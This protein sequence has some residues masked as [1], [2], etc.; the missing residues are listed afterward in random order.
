MSKNLALAQSLGADFKVKGDVISA[1]LSNT[2]DAN[3]WSSVADGQLL[4]KKDP[5]TYNGHL[6]NGFNSNSVTYGPGSGHEFEIDF[7]T[8]SANPWLAQINMD[9]TNYP[10]FHAQYGVEGGILS[11]IQMSGGN[12]TLGSGMPYSNDMRLSINDPSSLQSGQTGAGTGNNQYEGGW[13]IG[14][15]TSLLPEDYGMITLTEWPTDAYLLKVTNTSATGNPTQQWQKLYIERIQGPTDNLSATEVYLYIFQV[16]E[17]SAPV[18]GWE[19][20]TAN[21]DMSS[22]AD[23]TYLDTAINNLKGSAP[24]SLDTLKELSDAVIA[25][26]I[27][28]WNVY[29]AWNA[30]NS[31]ANSFHVGDGATTTFSFSHRPGMID[32]WVNGI[33]QTPMISSVDN[34]S[35]TPLEVLGSGYDYSSQSSSTT[36]EALTYANR[37]WQ[38]Y[39]SGGVLVYYRWYGDSTN[40]LDVTT[41]MNSF[42]ALGWNGQDA[43]PSFGV[44]WEYPFPASEDSKIT[45]VEQYTNDVF[46]GHLRGVR[47]LVPGAGQYGTIYL[48]PGN[49][50]T[51]SD[52]DT[53]LYGASFY[54]P[55]GPNVMNYD[56]YPGWTTGGT[57]TTDIS[58][59]Q[60]NP[61]AN[62][63]T[64][65]NPPENGASIEIRFW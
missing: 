42:S 7:T 3:L 18:P 12:P 60:A 30:E 10:V 8:D 16:M 43:I 38:A 40:H 65:A 6:I 27:S 33:L 39:T 57:V 37:D 20:T 21:A 19:P 63:I 45:L 56:A 11:S 46:Y 17:N 22:F 53:L 25:S 5:N 9:P 47:V 62:Q 36:T 13:Y 14:I 15:S 58:D 23:Q 4:L 55:G 41:M 49:G 61:T 34:S 31:S 28:T 54:G 2:S 64:F 51:D 1:T 26:P 29:K 24:A 44:T 59:D 50:Q 35:A 52:W 48:T 32:V